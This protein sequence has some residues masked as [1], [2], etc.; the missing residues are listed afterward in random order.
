MADVHD[1]GLLELVEELGGDRGGACSGSCWDGR[2][3]T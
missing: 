1:G 2:C 3:R